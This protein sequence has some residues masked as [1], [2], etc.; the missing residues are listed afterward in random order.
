MLKW[1]CILL[2]IV[3]FVLGAVFHKYLELKTEEVFSAQQLS[4]EVISI[5]NYKKYEL[6]KLDRKSVV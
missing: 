1:S 2:P 5:S 6:S 3:T 4:Y